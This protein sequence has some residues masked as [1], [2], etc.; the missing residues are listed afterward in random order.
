MC[1]QCRRNFPLKMP[2]SSF[3]SQQTLNANLTTAVHRMISLTH[4]SA[5]CRE[6]QISKFS[7]IATNRNP[8]QMLAEASGELT[9]GFPSW[10]PTP[11][12]WGRAPVPPGPSGPPPERNPTSSPAADWAPYWEE[13]GERERQREHP[14][15]ASAVRSRLERLGGIIKLEGNGG[16]TLSVGRADRWTQRH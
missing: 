6:Q 11:G 8:S 7:W 4:W 16:E 9:A 1:F 5:A 12:T 10:T 15:E 13:D 2:L 3:Y 14:P